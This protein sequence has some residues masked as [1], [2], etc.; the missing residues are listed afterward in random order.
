MALRNARAAR[1]R[2]DPR[3][4]Y[5]FTAA[6]SGSAPWHRSFRARPRPRCRG[7]T[8]LPEQLPPLYGRADDLA[9]L[10]ELVAAHTLVSVVGPGGIGKTC[11][12]RAAAHA[13]REVFADGVWIVELAP[14]TDPVLVTGTV[15]RLLE[16]HSEPAR[17]A[18]LATMLGSRRMLLVLDNCEHLLDAVAQ[19]AAEVRRQAPHVHVLATSQEPLKLADEQVYRLG[20]LA[21][22]ETASAAGAQDAGAVALFVAR[23]KAADPRFALTDANVATVIEICRRLDGIPLAIELAAA[24]VPL[25]G[26]EGLCARLNDRFRVLTAGARLALRRH[27]TLRAALEWSYGLLTGDEQAAFRRLG[28]FAGSFGLDSAQHVIAAGAIDAWAALDLLGTLVDKSLVVADAGPSRATACWKPGARS[29]SSS[30]PRPRR[31]PRQCAGTRRR[32][33]RCSSARGASGG[34]R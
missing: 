1:D 29:R 19:L 8:N 13:F 16:L 24:R 23:A 2:D 25:L 32:C 26:V 12:A 7:R 6:L 17:A 31:R 4:G 21:V 18:E 5:R 15:S 9:M 20:T 27:K 10:R 14:I 30:S 3:A 11:L 33:S 34:R 28:V 22:P